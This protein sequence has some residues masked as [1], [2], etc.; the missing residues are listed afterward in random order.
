M[1]GLRK[2]ALSAML[3]GALSDEIGGALDELRSELKT[4]I[5]EKR[6]AWNPRQNERFTLLKEL[7]RT[8]KGD[9]PEDVEAL[10]TTEEDAHLLKFKLMKEGQKRKPSSRVKIVRTFPSL[11]GDMTRTVEESTIS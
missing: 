7:I 2:R 4:L 10:K 6:Q 5:R 8:K 9:E 1:P 11:V 3:S